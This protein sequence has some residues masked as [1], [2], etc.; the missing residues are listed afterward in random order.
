MPVS[1]IM[2]Q[3]ETLPKEEDAIKKKKRNTA[4]LQLLS[5]PGV[6]GFGSSGKRV[7]AIM[8]EK[9]SKTKQI[10]KFMD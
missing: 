3:K 8:T 4:E 10:T 6:K 7:A 9:F 2:Y 5:L 1:A